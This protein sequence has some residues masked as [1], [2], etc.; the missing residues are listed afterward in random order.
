MLFGLSVAF[1]QILRF[2][3]VIVPH[4]NSPSSSTFLTTL[5]LYAYLPFPFPLIFETK[6]KGFPNSL[7]LALFSYMAISLN[8]NLKA[9]AHSYM[10]NSQIYIP[11]S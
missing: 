10:G 9:S 6:Y 7:C 5:F 3:P 11:H 8:L 2:L 1:V 4:T